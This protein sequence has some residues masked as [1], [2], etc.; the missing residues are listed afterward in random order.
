ML[1]FY[2]YQHL[3]RL[4]LIKSFLQGGVLILFP[5]KKN[6]LDRFFLKHW[7][8]Y[9]GISFNFTP[10]PSLS[11]SIALF[12]VA[13]CVSG[14]ELSESRLRSE[15]S[16]FQ[17]KYGKVYATTEE[18][19]KRFNIFKVNTFDLYTFVCAFIC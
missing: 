4:V 14:L 5:P 10:P 7:K 18:Q 13:C 17:A 1:I 15:F 3:V 11:K 9:L 6:K 8:C 2:F 16:E 19:E 12:V